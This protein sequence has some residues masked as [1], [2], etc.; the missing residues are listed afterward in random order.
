M[1]NPSMPSEFAVH[2]DQVRDGRAPAV[3]QNPER[4]FEADLPDQRTDRRGRGGSSPAIRRENRDVGC[5]QHDYA[6]RRRQD[7]LA[8]PAVSPGQQRPKSKGLAGR[9]PIAPGRGTQC[10]AH[11]QMSPYL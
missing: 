5:L 1:A 7:P 8:D 9:L 11:R 10:S 2:L 4:F 6:V 3:Y